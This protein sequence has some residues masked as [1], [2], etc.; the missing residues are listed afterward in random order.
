MFAKKV[1]EIL[2]R[3]VVSEVSGWRI[4]CRDT[5]SVTEF[6]YNREVWIFHKAFKRRVFP[7]FSWKARVDRDT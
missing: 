2:S 3:D 5:F 7:A 4:C 6:H 1:R